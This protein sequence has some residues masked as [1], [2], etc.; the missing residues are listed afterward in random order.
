MRQK[1]VITIN[2]DSEEMLLQEYSELDKDSFSLV[3]EEKYPLLT[4]QGAAGLGTQMLVNEIRTR[5]FFPCGPFADK[6]ASGIT[7]LL[8]QGN[9][10]TGEIVCNDV[11]YLARKPISEDRTVDIEDDETDVDDLVDDE[12]EDDFSDD[13]DSDEMQV[14]ASIEGNDEDD[15]ADED[16]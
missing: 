10:A 2:K 3:C 13:M 14:A 15:E 5:H 7:T 16:L 8:N 11:D 4:I 1:Y 9:D 12:F 6:I